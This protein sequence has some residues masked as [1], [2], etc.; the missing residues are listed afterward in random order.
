[1]LLDVPG[2][3]A[4]VFIDPSK[5]MKADEGYPDLFMDMR[6]GCGVDTPAEAVAYWAEWLGHDPIPDPEQRA[7]VPHLNASRWVA[8]CP[9]CGE[10]SWAWDLIPGWCCLHC[11]I[12]FDV[13]WPSPFLRAAVMRLVAGWP[14]V[15]RSWDAHL[16]E[17]VEQ[18]DRQGILMGHGTTIANG[19]EIAANIPAPD[20]FLDDAEALGRWRTQ[21]QQQR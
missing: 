2:A 1:M 5:P 17:T 18:L 7:V 19:F 11:G 14:A 16:G 13:A 8:L 12:V 20:D 6:H 21:P 9:D 3:T 15:N 4:R 10:R